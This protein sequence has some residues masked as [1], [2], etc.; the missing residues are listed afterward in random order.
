MKLTKAIIFSLVLFVTASFANRSEE[1]N[2]AEP[3]ANPT[4][5]PS[6]YQFPTGGGVGVLYSNGELVNSSGTGV[7]GLDESVLQSVTLGMGTLGFGHQVLNGNRIADDFTVPAGGWDIT[8]IT[9]YAYQT[10]ETASTITAVNLQIW[11]GDP[12]NPGSTVVF[13]DDT[14]NRMISTVN[15]NILRVT[16]TSTGTTTNRQIAASTVDVNISLPAGT[17]WLDWQSDGS[18]ASGP[19]AP[20]ITINGQSTTGNALQFTGSWTSVTDLSTGTQQGFP[21]VINGILPPPP[22]I[23]TTNWLGLTLLLMLLSF[24]SYRKLAK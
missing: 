15:S 1:N 3:V 9:F 18:G 4:V 6:S 11:D 12:S 21:F 19:W 2:S 14:T 16:E 24:I 17:Y 5:N 22:V 8:T 20:P 10:N 23:P 13:G 7:G